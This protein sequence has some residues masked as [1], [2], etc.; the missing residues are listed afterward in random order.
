MKKTI[1][2]YRTHFVWISEYF[3]S[4]YFLFDLDV[5]PFFNSDS[6]GVSVGCELYCARNF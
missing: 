5:W 2:E 3:L 1:N 6:F 4:E